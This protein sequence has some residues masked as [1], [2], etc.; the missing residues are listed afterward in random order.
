MN[1]RSKRLVT[2]MSLRRGQQGIA[3]RY[4]GAFKAGF[5]H[6]DITFDQVWPLVAIIVS[7]DL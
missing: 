2:C 1:S 4:E 3:K 6:N 7:Q 5:N